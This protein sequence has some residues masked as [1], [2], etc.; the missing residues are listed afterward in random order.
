[1][2]LYVDLKFR[3]ILNLYW[4]INVK[5][6]CQINHTT[7]MHNLTRINNEILLDFLFVMT[8][9]NYFAHLYRHMQY[10]NLKYLKTFPLAPFVSLQTVH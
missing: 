10:L 2:H 4:Y 7:L 8:F 1:M 9:E 3:G 5:F 6:A